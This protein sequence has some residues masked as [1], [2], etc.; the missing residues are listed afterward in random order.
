[1]ICAACD[2]TATESIIEDSKIVKIRSGNLDET[3]KICYNMAKL[4]SNYIIPMMTSYIDLVKEPKN[5][6]EQ[7]E[8]TSPNSNSSLQEASKAFPLNI[9]KK[10]YDEFSHKNCA[11]LVDTI[12]DL[13]INGWNQNFDKIYVPFP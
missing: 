13:V 8:S 11:Q 6:D 12:K 4:E 9:S 3:A 2:I 10:C 7:E 5:T 1:M